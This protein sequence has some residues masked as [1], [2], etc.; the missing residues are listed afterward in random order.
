VLVVV[1]AGV[2]VSALVTPGGTASRVV[3]AGVAGRFGYV[4]CPRLIS[5]L[6][7]VVER[8]KIARLVTEDQRRRFLTDVVAGGLD[9][10]D[11]THIPIV[12][13]DPDDDYLFAVAVEHDAEHIVTGDADLLDV[14]EPPVPVIGVR[15]FLDALTV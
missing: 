13:R 1:D 7:E 3:A 14:T 12:S 6:L 8:P 10:D 4:L 11:P 2:F 9:V 5:E 15:A